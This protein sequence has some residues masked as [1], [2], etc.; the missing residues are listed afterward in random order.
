MLI[1]AFS[2]RNKLL[3]QS[4]ASLSNEVLPP[5]LRLLRDFHDWLNNDYQVKPSSKMMRLEDANEGHYAFAKTEIAQA[6]QTDHRLSLPSRAAT[7]L[8]AYRLPIQ[9]SNNAPLPEKTAQQV[10][11][12]ES[13]QSK[14]ESHVSLFELGKTLSTSTPR[15]MLTS[16]FL[17][18]A[19]VYRK[20]DS[21]VQRVM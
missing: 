18:H 10:P 19:A 5:D 14:E 21:K 4:Y 7:T 12:Q 16:F 3:L 2:V 1:Q 17:D 11:T 20:D 13:G 6:R 9:H 15:F 8:R